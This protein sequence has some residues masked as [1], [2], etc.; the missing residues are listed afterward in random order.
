MPGIRLTTAD[1][2][3][4]IVHLLDG[5]ARLD[6]ETRPAVLVRIDRLPESP[7]DDVQFSLRPLPDGV[8]PIVVLDGFV[9]PPEWAGIGV[10]ARGRV[11]QEDDVG[12]T[13]SDAGRATVVAVVARDGTRVSGLRM[14]DGPLLV[15]VAEPGDPVVGEL[16]LAL[17]RALGVPCAVAGEPEGAHE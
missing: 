6:D 2:L 13:R 15:D 12:V 14:R 7:A 16:S 9:A 5:A 1:V 10:V 8:H 3:R 11:T 17:C 4:S